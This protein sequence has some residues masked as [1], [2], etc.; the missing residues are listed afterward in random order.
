MKTNFKILIVFLSLSV[1]FFACQKVSPEEQR[2]I[3]IAAAD[4][5]GAVE[6]LLTTAETPLPLF[7][8]YY[9]VGAAVAG[10][11]SS[12]AEA[13]LFE[14]KIPIVVDLPSELKIANNPQEIIGE[15]HNQA[16]DYSMKNILKSEFPK[17][18]NESYS[19]KLINEAADCIS[20]NNVNK[21]DII[22]KVNS[23]YLLNNQKL[24][25][26]FQKYFKND[27]I[28]DFQNLDQTNSL[29]IKAKSFCIEFTTNFKNVKTNNILDNIR[30]INSEIV[31]I[32]NNSDDEKL[33]T[34]KLTFLSVYKHSY[35]YWNNKE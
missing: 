25:R 28:A 26:N 5:A 13:S 22:N 17:L 19:K 35:Y 30:Y 18:M 31:K 11:M 8:W 15:M 27:E 1:S 21:E 2:A 6:F 16:L 29:A 23:Y 24:N 9:A 4:A 10:A 20:T 32:I 7:P 3:D 14:P 12:A 34:V 33:K